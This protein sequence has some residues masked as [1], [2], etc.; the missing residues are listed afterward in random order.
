M[1]Q[2]AAVLGEVRC[3]RLTKEQQQ[4]EEEKEL[5]AL[6]PVRQQQ[7]ARPQLELSLQ[8]RNT[9]PNRVRAK[10]RSFFT[11][12]QTH[13]APGGM[14]WT[15]SK[16]LSSVHGSAVT[17]CAILEGGT[18]TWALS[19]DAHGRLMCHNLS[20]HLSVAAQALTSFASEFTKSL[21]TK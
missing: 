20:R 10:S 7:P 21:V 12:T 16:A 9:F 13:P 6:W 2:P 4:K 1:L 11:L 15:L 3:R 8:W 17:A 18:T 19:S 14:N 5:R